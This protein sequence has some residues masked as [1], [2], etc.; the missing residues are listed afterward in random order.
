[1]AVSGKIDKL[2]GLKENVIVG[3]PI[4]AGTG[5]IMNGYREIAA[6][7]DEVLA[8]EQAKDIENI[9]EVAIDAAESPAEEV[10]AEGAE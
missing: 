10:P 3:R 7:R 9:E 1:A 6:G 4:P 2:I 8:E 5:K